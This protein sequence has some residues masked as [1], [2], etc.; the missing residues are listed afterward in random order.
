MTLGE[1]RR[2]VRDRFALLL[3]PCARQ[4][5]ALNGAEAD[6][7]CRLFGLP[8]INKASG[9]T[10]RIGRRF[11]ARS[12]PASNSIG[13]VQPVILSTTHAGATIQIGDDVGISGSA[14]SAQRLIQIGHRVGSE[15]DD[16]GGCA[17][18]P[19]RGEPHGV[20]GSEG[21]DAQTRQQCQSQDRLDHIA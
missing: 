4:W 20:A 1:F 9:S 15:P 17:G 16:Q 10:I 12:T 21:V 13:V 3:S 18:Q 6:T 14:L 19:N 7:G 8:I 2:K 11:T 5:L